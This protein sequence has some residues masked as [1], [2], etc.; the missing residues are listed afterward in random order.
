MS[1]LCAVVNAAA[2]TECNQIFQNSLKLLMKSQ[3]HLAEAADIKKAVKQH[4][5]EF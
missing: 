4:M 5:D 1:M 3:H 2:A